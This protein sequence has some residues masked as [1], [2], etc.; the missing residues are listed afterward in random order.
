MITVTPPAVVSIAITP[1]K[2]SITQGA[3]KQF[4]AT[5]TFT[6]GTTKNLT[7]AATWIAGQSSIA[8]IDS[9]GL[10]TAE[11]V[12]TTTIT[13]ASGTV[14]GS[15]TLK[16]TSAVLKS[17]SIHPLNPSVPLGSATQLKVAGNYSDGT[18][19][20]LTQ[21]VSWSVFYPN[22]ASIDATGSTVGKQMG[23]TLVT[24]TLNSMSSVIN[25]TVTHASLYSIVVTPGHQY[26][27]SG[28]SVQLTA[29]GN[30]LDGSAQDITGDVTWAPSANGV[31][32]V[33]S[34]GLVTATGSGR[35]R[36]SATSG[37]YSASAYLIVSPVSLN[38]VPADSTL[39][40]GTSKQLQAI[41]TFNDG[42]TSD[43][44]KAVTWAAGDPSIV[45]MT[46]S[47]VA[48]SQDIGLSTVSATAGPIS[49]SGNVTVEPAHY[50]NYFNYA[51]SA[52]GDETFRF[53]QSGLTGEN[54]CAMVYVFA[55]DQQLSECCGCR[56]TANGLLTL[57]LTN[58]L[59][60][61]P[62]TGQPLTRGTIEVVPAKPA[63]NTCDPSSFFPGGTVS[64]WTTHL[65][66]RPSGSVSV[67][68]TP[69][70][71]VPVNFTDLGTMQALCSFINVAGS[72]QG[73]C[74]CGTGD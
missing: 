30:Y 61:N 50:V 28:G 49:G 36:V 4:Q 66:S 57:S 38:V 1:A 22:V 40:L 24:A 12:G 10:A 41:A 64:A 60:L 16:I 42:S 55:P 2:A 59:N 46:D 7:K 39:L 15:A 54:L 62:L 3:T 72:G 44:S 17:I 69:S 52:G 53:T 18:E 71:A 73:T 35:A 65:E 45:Q 26:L 43:V 5:G 20:D 31:V 19:Q 21:Q 67:T 14:T 56:I 13:A 74:T 11:D 25:L 34:S 27:A 9:S 32:D 29:T 6:D 68:E 37:Q 47:G 51:N 23:T 63:G 70:A 33:T 58:D 48:V 8:T